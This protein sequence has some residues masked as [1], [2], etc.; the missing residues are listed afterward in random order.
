[1]LSSGM[2]DI[3]G[4]LV[5]FCYTCVHEN[6]L[7]RKPLTFLYSALASFASRTLKCVSG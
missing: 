6:I 5:R 1:M 4:L 7:E 3:M 2:R